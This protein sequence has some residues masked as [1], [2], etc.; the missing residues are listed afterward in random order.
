MAEVTNNKTIAK[1]TILLY[2]KMMFT[3]AVSLYTSRVILDV[4]GIDDY[5]IYQAVGGVVAMLSFVNGALAVGSSRFITYELGTGN[6][7]K[8]KRTFSSLLSVHIVLA[9]IVVVASETIG[10]WFVNNKLVIP[11]DRM[12]AALMAYHISILTAA[13]NIIVVPYSSSVIAH[14]RMGIFASISILDAILKLGICYM[15][16]IGNIDKLPLYALLLLMVQIINIVLYRAYCVRGFDETHYKPMWDK[17][18][19]KDVLGYSGWNLL[20]NTALALITY[21]STILLN[22]F[23]TS[24][25]VTAMAVSNQINGAAQQFVNSFR[26][27]AIPQIVKKFATG[28]ITGSKKLLLNSTKYSFYLMLLL[29]L[30]ILLVA[31]DLLHLWLK[32]VPAYTTS[33]VQLTVL[34]CLFQVFDSSFYTAL[35]AKGRIKENAIFSPTVLFL[36]FPLVYFMFKSGGSPLCLSWG[37]MVAYAFLGLLVKPLLIIQIAGYTWKEIIIVFIDCIKVLFGSLP[38]P[39]LSFFYIDSITINPFLRFLLLITISLLCI[40]VSVWFIGLSSDIRL[41]I[42]NI[43]KSR[44]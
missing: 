19:L 35:Y 17:T 8:L 28:D 24:A 9:L 16:T 42:I 26:T 25:V 14:E 7:E 34:T 11:T 4:L 6:R 31:D 10:L 18:I 38:V 44:F 5:G 2:F 21:G 1:N 43:A 15:L 23:F 41:K 33:F 29:A 30:P 27:A 39:L 40:F 32:V 12:T 13:V 37:L 36:L 20:A 22:M 3:M